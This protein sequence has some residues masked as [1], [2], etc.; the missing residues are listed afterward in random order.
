M[1]ILFKVITM[2]EE[3][4]RIDNGFEKEDKAIILLG[5]ICFILFI[6]VWIYGSWMS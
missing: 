1:D 4:E 6:S 3:T 5:I 2:T